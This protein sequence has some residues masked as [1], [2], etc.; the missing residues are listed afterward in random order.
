MSKKDNIVKWSIVG[1]FVALYS[2]VSIISTIHVIDFFRLSNPE[3]L[4]IT[5]AIAFEVGAA[6]CLGAI[7]ILNRTSRWLVWSLFILITAMQ[8]MGNMYYAYSHLE[9]FQSWSELF[10]LNEEEPIFQKRILSIVSGAILPIVALGFIKSLVDYIRPSESVND[11]I[12]DKSIEDKAES[13]NDQITDSVTQEKPENLNDVAKRVWKKVDELREAGLLPEITQEDIE[14]EP[15]ALANSGYRERAEMAEMEKIE[16]EIIE[17]E[18]TED[19]IQ[20]EIQ[21]QDINSELEEELDRSIEYL[22]SEE[23]KKEEPKKEEKVLKEVERKIATAI[24]KNPD[25]KEKISEEIKKMDE[26]D[27]YSKREESS[28]TANVNVARRTFGGM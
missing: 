4:A 25:L 13:I 17:E 18:I 28:D 9:N 26:G 5:L 8:M 16:E 6:A 15:T 21:E 23:P 10:A 11:Q 2:M 20:E 27:K 19:E 1:I 7:V 22:S 3:W 14:N 12:N 24:A